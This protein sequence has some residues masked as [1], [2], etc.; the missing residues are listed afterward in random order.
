MCWGVWIDDDLYAVAVYGNGVNC[1]Q[2]GFLARTTGLTVTQENHVELKRLARTEPRHPT[3]QLTRLIASA[4]RWLQSKGYNYIV[5]FSDP[6]Q[7]HSGSIYRAA[8]FAHIGHT[9]AEWHVVDRSGKQ[10]H[11]RVAYRH[12]RRHGCTI[13]QSRKK[14]GLKRVKTQP[15]DRWFLAT[16]RRDRKAMASLRRR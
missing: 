16:S 2:A 13:E 1:Y 4:H 3:F 9:Q 12:S 5:S 6:E 7:G 11:R 8:N 15:R 14:L 10:Q